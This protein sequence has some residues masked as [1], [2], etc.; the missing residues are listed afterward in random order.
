MLESKCGK[1]GVKVRQWWLFPRDLGW[2]EMR[3]NQGQGATRKVKVRQERVTVRQ[4]RVT[5]RQE[6]VKMR[7]GSRLKMQQNLLKVGQERVEARQVSNQS[8]PATHAS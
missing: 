3:Q 1:V 7:Q 5:A 2:V 6:K 8:N 4:E